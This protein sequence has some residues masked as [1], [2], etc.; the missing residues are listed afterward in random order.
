VAKDDNPL[1]YTGS[2]FDPVERGLLAADGNW[3][4]DPA[5]FRAVEKVNHQTNQ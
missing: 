3:I 4:R 2:M 5:A 1:Q